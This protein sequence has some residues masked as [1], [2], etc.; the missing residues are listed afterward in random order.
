M[1]CLR[2]RKGFEEY[3]EFKKFDQLVF[4]SDDINLLNSKHKKGQWAQFSFGNIDKQAERA[5]K[6]LEML[7]KREEGTGIEG[8]SGS[9]GE[10][11]GEAGR[12]LEGSLSFLQ[13]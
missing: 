4:R 3:E 6:G 12:V 11:F 1:E 10:Q 9:V 2:R 5:E 7:W 8:G 13:D